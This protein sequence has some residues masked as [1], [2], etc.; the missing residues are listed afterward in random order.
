M[1]K[2]E[3]VSS[4]G[5]GKYVVR[6]FLSVDSIKVEIQSL[7]KRLAELAV[8][9]PEKKTEVLQK[10]S[11]IEQV[12]SEIDDWLGLYLTD[13][14]AARAGLRNSQSQLVRLNSQLRLLN[15]YLTQLIAE[16][17]S[18]L[19]RRNLLEGIPEYRQF[20]A[21]CADYSPEMAGEVGL[22]DIND[23]GGQG[24]LVQPGYLGGA[25]YDAA[26]DGG[27]FPYLAQSGPQIFFNAAILPGVQKWLPRYRVGTITQLT[28]DGASVDLDPAESSA[29]GLP[30]NQNQTLENIPVVYMDCNSAAFEEGDRVVVRF[31]KSG[32]LV[33][34]FES[35]P[36]A[37][38]AKIICT[39]MKSTGVWAA[40]YFGAPFEDENGQEINPPLGTIYGAGGA[41][42][43]T[44]V[45]DK[46]LRGVEQNYGLR[47]WIGRG[48][49]D[50]LSWHGPASRICGLSHELEGID[51][52][53]KYSDERPA[54]DSRV[55]YKGKVICDLYFVNIH[56]DFRTVDGAAIVY[57]ADRSQRWL[58]VCASNMRY[59]IFS[60][61]QDPADR[62]SCRIIDIPWNG[63]MPD[64]A[65]A[66]IIDS[67]DSEYLIPPSQGMYFSESGAKAV[68][69]FSREI[70]SILAVH[71]SSATSFTEEPIFLP[72]PDGEGSYN[73]SLTGDVYSGVIET[74][75]RSGFYPDYT[76]IIGYE[77]VGETA[78]RLEYRR[79][80]VQES[81]FS[82][83]R[84]DF[85]LT[86]LTYVNSGTASNPNN[87][88]EQCW[89]ATNTTVTLQ[90]QRTVGAASV[91]F[92]AEKL[93]GAERPLTSS[94]QSETVRSGSF[95]SLQVNGS[96][97]ST[98][99][100]DDFLRTGALID[101]RFG[102]FACEYQSIDDQT[103]TAFN[104][105]SST[106]TRVTTKD[107]RY[108]LYQNGQVVQEIAPDPYTNTVV[109]V[110]PISGDFDNG[111]RCDQTPL[112]SANESQSGAW[113]PNYG[114]GGATFHINAPNSALSKN[115]RIQQA[116][117]ISFGTG[118]AASFEWF[119]PLGD[120]EYELHRFT[121]MD[122]AGDPVQYIL[123]KSADDGYMIGNFSLY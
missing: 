105:T 18:K 109:T 86:S 17:L 113:T 65:G 14:E 12:K 121:Y 10:E 97:T 122:G 54:Y 48:P 37:C 70:F 27:L 91:W 51:S 93:V 112:D 99:T 119:Y 111:E 90:R 19:K 69:C 78:T 21:W 84:Q 71:W 32:P 7:T 115:T 68:I 96:S 118:V 40:D 80:S 47:N 77:F 42:V 117:M 59:G 74:D 24:I 1:S 3:I 23:E 83:N 92:G 79:G 98:T 106:Q 6:Q 94:T 8:Q 100:S 89:K 29:Q 46:Y 16:N 67:Y 116:S 38:S 66:E 11:E 20:E 64:L 25:V 58:R 108:R 33:I 101:A 82:S 103:Q 87:Y 52:L 62:Y 31:T 55:F 110:N 123:N 57:G 104:G 56:P 9:I 28:I 75:T 41:W 53:N 36:K 120:N 95:G 102:L 13:Q 35:E 15:I 39:P 43:F 88:W 49:S 30:I 50:V 107:I 85:Q 4:L 60:Q 81:V 114:S 2:G 22:I 44:T 73:Y 45:P 63:D 34:G 72:G 61:W 5:E 76:Q 26:R